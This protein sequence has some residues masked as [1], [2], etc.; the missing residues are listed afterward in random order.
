MV[1]RFESELKVSSGSRSGICDRV[2]DDWLKAM[3]RP[4]RQRQ[5][6]GCPLI[7]IILGEL[8]LGAGA[9]ILRKH[10]QKRELATVHILSFCE[11]MRS[12]RFIRA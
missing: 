2:P 8:F 3:Y 12:I 10:T 1:L 5:G 9:E 7:V 11:L 4:K 6:K